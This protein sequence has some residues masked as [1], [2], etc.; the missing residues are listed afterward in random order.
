MRM[1]RALDARGVGTVI[2]TSDAN[3]PERLP[4][5]RGT[6]QSYEGVRT[7][8]FPRIDERFKYSPSLATWLSSNS[9]RFDV[10]HIHA[11]FSHAS[12]AAARVCRR[13]RVPYVLRP[14][15]ALDPRELGRNRIQRRM[16]RLV[17]VDRMLRDAAAVH[18]TTDEERRLAEQSF[19]NLR[20]VVI[21]LGVDDE[22]LE[23]SVPAFDERQPLVATI[24]RI[25]PAKN[26]ET[27]IRAF[28]AVTGDN[29]RR[30]WRL[31]IA[32]DGEPEYRQTLEA[33]AG[34][35]RTTG[36]M[37]FAGWITGHDKADLL[38]RAS[39]FV[40]ASHQGSFGLSIVEAMARGVPV[41]ASR[42]V[43]LADAIIGAGAGWVVG[44]DQASIGNTLV[45]AMDNAEERRRRGIAA[46]S[47]AE[48]FAWSSIA[49][50]LEKLYSNLQT[51]LAPGTMITARE[52]S[53]LVHIERRVS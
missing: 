4:V 43:N 16:L 38:E 10:V 24:G 7:I 31:V 15:G 28:Q 25:H 47:A 5:T 22:L 40:Q 19:R 36:R 11:V 53:P 50:T 18:F 27:I 9:R 33:L 45:N 39:L 46:R 26:L 8:F 3:G 48:R 12:L 29:R 49:S 6:E 34:K 21:P 44:T 2:A 23:P 14:L 42:T 17:A 37:T 20:S 35:E 13:E 52:S 30:H 41:I 32:G 1:C 51:G